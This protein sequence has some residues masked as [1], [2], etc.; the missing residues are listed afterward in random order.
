MYLKCHLKTVYI[1]NQR[2]NPLYIDTL[3]GFWAIYQWINLYGPLFFAELILETVY[4]KNQR[5]NPLYI[6][7]LHGFWD[8]YQWINLL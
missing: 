7:T 4:I 8:I 1:K 3:H 2:V 6:D 5:A